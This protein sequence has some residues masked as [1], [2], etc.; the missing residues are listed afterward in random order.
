M[1]ATTIREGTTPLSRNRYTSGIPKHAPKRAPHTFILARSAIRRIPCMRAPCPAETN[2][3]NT[4][5][6]SRATAALRSVLPNV[7]WDIGR[8][9]TTSRTAP[10][11]PSTREVRRK[12]AAVC[13]TRSSSPEPAA[14]AICRTPLLLTPK[15]C[16]ILC[17]VCDRPIQA[18]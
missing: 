3:N 1:P 8:Q 5:I 9:N 16:E 13:A 18:K 11:T 12:T 10:K 6:D 14:S 15:P 4:A 7:N 17:K 2:L